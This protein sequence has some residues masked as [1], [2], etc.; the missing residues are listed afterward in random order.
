MGII[1]PYG[2]MTNHELAQI[3]EK[4]AR[5]KKIT[6][7]TVTKNAVGNGRIYETLMAGGSCTLTI[8]NKIVAYAAALTDDS[9]TPLVQPTAPHK[10]Q[11]AS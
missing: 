9:A 4:I 11:V 8:A 5:E 10:P 2:G 1:V 3:I 6:P 7:A